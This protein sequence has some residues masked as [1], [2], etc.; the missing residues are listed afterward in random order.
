MM[1]TLYTKVAYSFSHFK[2]ETFLTSIYVHVIWIKILCYVAFFHAMSQMLRSSNKSRPQTHTHTLSLSLS[3]KMDSFY[4][5]FKKK[6]EEKLGNQN[7][8]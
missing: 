2:E 6:K 4:N 1:S 8:S 3:L 5:P 7:F